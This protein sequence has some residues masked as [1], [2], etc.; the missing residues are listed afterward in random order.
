MGA[1]AGG[2]VSRNVGGAGGPDVGE[3]SV[4]CSEDD[5]DVARLDRD[6]GERLSSSTSSWSRS[7]SSSL[8]RHLGF[9]AGGGSVSGVEIS[10][11][12]KSAAGTAATTA[13]LAEDGDDDGA[14]SSH[15]A[16]AARPRLRR[17][18]RRRLPAAL[19]V[20]AGAG[21]LHDTV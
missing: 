11:V 12:G 6:S 2:G 20:T 3:A 13:I 15:A 4:T 19:S 8:R 18:R 16:V 7:S 10:G 5:G 9:L 21:M 17:R 1:T 14:D